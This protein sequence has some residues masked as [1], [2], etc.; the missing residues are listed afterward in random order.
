VKVTQCVFHSHVL[1]ENEVTSAREIGRK[2]YD[3]EPTYRRDESIWEWTVTR[4]NGRSC[5]GYG[6]EPS[7]G[8][9]HF[10]GVRENEKGRKEVSRAQ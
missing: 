7:H 6:A 2:K 1:Q 10:M 4:K 5:H 8:E 9:K 3:G